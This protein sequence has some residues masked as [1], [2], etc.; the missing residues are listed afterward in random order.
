M[1]I[2]NHAIERQVERSISN[3]LLDLLFDFGRSTFPSYKNSEV[4]YFDKIAKRNIKKLSPELYKKY[5][6]DF[7]VRAIIA[8]DSD[9]VVTVTRLS[10]KDKAIEKRTP[11][12]NAL[13]LKKR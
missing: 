5:E 8:K 2:T 7:S 10:R 12:R 1:K 11:Y 3:E 4:I 6:K 13:S 9:Y